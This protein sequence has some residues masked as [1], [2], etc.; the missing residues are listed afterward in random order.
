[1]GA[2]DTV[3]GVLHVPFC[4]CLARVQVLEDQLVADAWTP[5]QET[6]SCGL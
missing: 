2:F 3:P 1:M 6:A 4:C 5:F